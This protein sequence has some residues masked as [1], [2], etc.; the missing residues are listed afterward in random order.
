MS[1][2]DSSVVV[3]P[4]R[5]RTEDIPAAFA[6]FDRRSKAGPVSVDFAAVEDFDS[7]ALA[8][9]NYLRKCGA[10]VRVLNI[11]ERL[12]RAYQVFLGE[13]PDSACAVPE[14]GL[15]LR[16]IHSF[17]ERFI[18]WRT[19]F[20]NFL[21]LLGDEAFHTFSYLR[22]RRGVYPGEVWNQL[23]FMGYKSYPITCLL[24]F[25]IGVTIALT[26]AAQLKLYGAEIYVADIMGFAILREFQPIMTGMILS[27][28]IGAAVTAELSTMVVLEEVDALKTMAVVP[29]RFL[30]VP[31]LLAITLA[32]PLL[33]ALADLVG[34]GAGIIVGRVSLGIAPSAFLREMLTTVGIGDFLIGLAKTVLF[35]WT[36]VL[37]AGFKGL[38][39]GRSAGEVGRAT[40]QCV[41]LSIFSIIVLDCIIALLIY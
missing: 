3:L 34:I 18:A 40:T 28:K 35:G 31:R 36:I 38:S 9:L 11:G 20:V 27:G 12:G 17:S 1:P 5:L 29:E 26:M 23:L 6:D 25:L 13:T 14:L 33:T 8:F 32:T 16:V 19:G 2:V 22:R 24:I 21:V 15:P 39:V 41:V 7:S 4:K 37:V 10:D 30:M